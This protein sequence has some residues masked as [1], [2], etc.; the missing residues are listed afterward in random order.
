MDEFLGSNRR[1]SVHE[2]GLIDLFAIAHLAGRLPKR[3]A[4]IGIQPQIIAWGDAPST[5]V[6]GAIRV[7]CHQALRLIEDWQA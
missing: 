2:V 1:L 7:A 5:P 3:R 6:C 4:L